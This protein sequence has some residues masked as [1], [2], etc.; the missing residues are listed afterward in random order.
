M[1]RE[2]L[3]AL[4]SRNLLQIIKRLEKKPDDI[5]IAI[6][7]EVKNE[8]V[9]NKVK[10]VYRNESPR[11]SDRGGFSCSLRSCITETPGL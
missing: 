2:L 5:Y 9:G 8:A 4:V 11:M 3:F 1:G 6:S 10:I 7:A